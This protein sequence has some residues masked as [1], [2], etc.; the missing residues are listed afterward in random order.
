MIKNILCFGDSW[1]QN[2][3]GKPFVHW[4]ADYF[5]VTHKNF[6]LGGSSLGLITHTVV[7]NLKIID[8]NS[9]VLIVVP[10]DF[11][12]YSESEKGFF[13]LQDYCSVEYSTFFKGK[14][15]EWFRYHH[16]FFIYSLQKIL[17][18]KKCNYV[19]MH[20]FGQLE[21]LQYGLNISRSKFLNTKSLHE[22]LMINSTSWKSYP[23]PLTEPN[24]PDE[25]YFNGPYF[26]GNH[27][28]EK[29]HQEIARQ[30]IDFLK[31]QKII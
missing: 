27:P 17:E 25:L 14:T 9:L 4:V 5:K 30:I 12:W 1:G 2:H 7:S 16:S 15:S 19:M 26:E 11:R 28:N 13:S 29:G 24:G 8:E 21:Y 31:N 22:L 6:S 18:D 23:N 10:P 20:N 3:I